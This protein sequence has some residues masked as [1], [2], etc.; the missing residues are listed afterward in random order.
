M[1]QT[2]WLVHRWAFDFGFYHSTQS[3]GGSVQSACSL[4]E[5]GLQESGGSSSWPHNTRPH[6]TH[7][8]RTYTSE[9]VWQAGNT[10]HIMY[11]DCL[12]SGCCNATPS[13]WSTT[14]ASPDVRAAWVV[15]VWQGDQP[16]IHVFLCK[17]FGPVVK[18]MT[19]WLWL[20]GLDHFTNILWL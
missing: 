20:W 7:Q 3:S 17:V 6:A 9:D 4:Q 13:V 18:R 12:W 15:C 2:A 19:S 10:E 14:R 5:C 1:Y 8:P 16:S 11:A